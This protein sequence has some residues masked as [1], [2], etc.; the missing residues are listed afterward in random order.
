MSGLHAQNQTF[1]VEA[2]AQYGTFTNDNSTDQKVLNVGAAYYFKPVELNSA[3]PF[4]ELDF[5]QKAGY[6]SALYSNQKIETSTFNSATINPLNLAGRVY[7]NDIVLGLQTSSWSKTMDLKAGV[8]N[9]GI[10]SNSV[11]FDVGY[12]VLP[13]TVASYVYS[14]NTAQYSLS[15]GL[16]AVKDLNI[17][18]NGIKSHT[19][20]PLSGGQSVA[21]DLFYSNVTY[22]QTTSQSN[23]EYGATVK[24][25]PV[26]NAYISTGYKISS[27]DYAS[28]KGNTF[29]LGAGYAFT[30]RL[31][32]LL[33]TSKFNVDDSTQKSGSTTTLLTLGY[34][35]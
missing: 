12:F 24:F 9:V 5:L 32:V 6:V 31:G 8:G 28:D 33:S 7:L 13:T 17:T 14:K 35:F 18:T 26:T 19:L 29:V 27:G 22:E 15:V 21:F 4:T 30:P 1:N 20:M 25:F 11:G 3:Q 23:N 10:N 16:P 34:R 2:A